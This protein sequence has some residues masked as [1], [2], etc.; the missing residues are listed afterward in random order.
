MT[1][2]QRRAHLWAWLLATLAILACAVLALDVRH[3]VSAALTPIDSG[4]AR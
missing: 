1:R 4:E 3:R 2:W